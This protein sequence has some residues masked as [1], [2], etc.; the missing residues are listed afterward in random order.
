MNQ[1]SSVCAVLVSQ[2]LS[3]YLSQVCFLPT[4]GFLRSKLVKMLGL[5][6]NVSKIWF[7]KFKIWFIKI[8]IGSK[9][10]FLRSKLA[11]ILVCNVKIGPKLG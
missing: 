5:G 9:Y 10:W 3:K 2:Y 8:K 11:K 6:Q 7:I 1:S 4:F